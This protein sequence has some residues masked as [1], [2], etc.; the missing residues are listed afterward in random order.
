[1][2]WYMYMYIISSKVNVHVHCTVCNQ[3]H[4]HACTWL[5]VVYLLV[6]Y[7][8]YNKAWKF[9][10]SF[11]FAQRNFLICMFFFY[12]HVISLHQIKI[13]HN[14]FK[15]FFFSVKYSCYTVLTCVYIQVNLYFYVEAKILIYYY[16]DTYLYLCAFLVNLFTQLMPFYVS[17]SLIDRRGFIDDSEFEETSYGATNPISTDVVS[18]WILNI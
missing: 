5:H 9:H 17:F 10:V 14:F 1:M 16:Y 15:Q 3:Y 6:G 13:P 12:F 11:I 7:T 8:W 2:I 4:F 18:L